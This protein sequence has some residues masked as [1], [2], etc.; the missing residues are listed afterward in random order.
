MSIPQTTLEQWAVLHTVMGTGS[1]AKA[2]ESLNRSQSAV[3]YA[4]SQL[5]ERL[6]TRLLQIEGRKAQLTDAGP[7]TRAMAELLS[8]G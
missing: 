7:A 4:V 6:G 2:A 5:Q 1:F 3:S 8:A